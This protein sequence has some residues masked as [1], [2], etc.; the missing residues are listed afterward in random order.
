MI[1]LRRGVSRLSSES[2]SGYYPW[3]NVKPNE[4]VFTSD[5][6][7]HKYYLPDKQLFMLAGAM[8]LGLFS[9]NF[10]VKKLFC[11][12]NPPNPPRVFEEPPIRH[13]HTVDE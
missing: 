2:S 5:Y 11:K 12:T 9:G 4:K 6:F 8:T 1:S 7:T 10:A 13:I 3:P